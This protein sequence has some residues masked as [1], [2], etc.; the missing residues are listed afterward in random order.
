MSFVRRELSVTITIAEGKL[1]N[2]KGVTTTLRDLRM[3]ATVE[4]AGGAAQGQLQAKIHG[5][6]LEMINALTQ[7]GPI[8]TQV[9]RQNTI[10]IA[11]GDEGEAQNIVF[12]GVIREAYGDFQS[13]PDVAL[14]VVANSA[15]AAAIVP[16]GANSWKGAKDAAEIMQELAAIAGFVFENNGVSVILSNPYLPGTA[17]TQIQLCA[18]AANINYSTDNGILAIW[19][20]DGQRAGDIPEVS[21]EKGNLVGYPIFTSN[22]LT[23]NSLFLPNI[24]NGGQVKL[25][26]QI[27]IVNGIWRVSSIYHNLETKRDNGAWFTQLRVYNKNG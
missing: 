5:I 20:Q 26:S 25:V 12:E 11:A 9:R 18:R 14:M 23:V 10:Q 13:A 24:K 19:P 3:S 6:P 4:V 1:G 16:V 7:I 17:L 8:A 22:G 2:E 27:P 15:L 21:K